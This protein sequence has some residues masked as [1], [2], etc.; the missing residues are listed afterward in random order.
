MIRMY[1]MKK[2]L[3]SIKKK[4]KES[5]PM[6][7]ECKGSTLLNLSSRRGKE[8]PHTLRRSSHT[9]AYASSTTPT[10]SIISF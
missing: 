5:F 3:S 2:I 4:K 8:V 6:A 7:M 10:L 9:E 1:Y